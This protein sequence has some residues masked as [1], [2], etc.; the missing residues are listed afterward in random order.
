M[1]FK[2]RNADFARLDGKLFSLNLDG[3]MTGL[4]FVILFIVVIIPIFMIVYNAFF[5]ERAFDA[6]LF[7]R[8]IGNKDNI[9]AM[10]NTIV[11]AFWVTVLGTVVG[12]FYA[13]LLGRSD[14]P[15]KGL[16]RSLFTIPYMFPPFF[17]AMAWDLMLSARGGYVNN[18]LMS[19]LHLEKAPININSIWGIVFVSKKV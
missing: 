3:V 14:I 16:M 2:H 8:V 6:K 4:S 9:G 11:I 18:W 10:W 17:G 5:F 1:I 13:W 15:L 12:L 19:V 7:A